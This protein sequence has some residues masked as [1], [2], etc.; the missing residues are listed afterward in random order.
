MAGLS[1]FQGHL[2]SFAIA[3]VA[4]QNHTRRLPQRGT[5]RQREVGGVAVQ[6]TLVDGRTLVIVQKLD[7]VL[8]GDD[9]TGVLIVDAIEQRGQSRGLA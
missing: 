8:D 3:Q 2:H 6:L 1:G 9:V 4:D 7:R 5:E